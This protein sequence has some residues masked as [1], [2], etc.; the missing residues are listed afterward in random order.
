M[1]LE[2]PRQEVGRQRQQR[3]LGW[4]KSCPLLTKG[5][6]GREKGGVEVGG[7]KEGR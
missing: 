7:E 4:M 6:G 5:K 3:G 1:R 2:D